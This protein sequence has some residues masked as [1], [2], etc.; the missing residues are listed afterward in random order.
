MKTTVIILIS[1]I[2]AGCASQQK[3]TGEKEAPMVAVDGAVQPGNVITLIDDG[4][5]HAVEVAV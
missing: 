1:I 3:L 5:E 2:L 4:R